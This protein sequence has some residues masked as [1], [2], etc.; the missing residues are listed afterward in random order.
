MNDV[1]NINTLHTVCVKF[2][3]KKFN[4]VIYLH[5]IIIDK[6]IKQ[7]NLQLSLYI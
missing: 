3:I 4:G 5:N 7:I 1:K 2:L 6:L